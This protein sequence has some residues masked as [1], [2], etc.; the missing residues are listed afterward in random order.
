MKYLLHK[1]DDE[2]SKDVKGGRDVHQTLQENVTSVA[3]SILQEKLHYS[4]EL[5]LTVS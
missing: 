2:Y 1:K 3:S 5:E 4:L